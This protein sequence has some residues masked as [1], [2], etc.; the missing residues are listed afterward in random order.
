ME[1]SWGDSRRINMA[2]N[3]LKKNFG[4]RIQKVTIDAGFTC[5]NRDGTLGKG[6]CAYCN[7]DAFNPSYCTTNKPVSQQ[8]EEGIEFHEKRYKGAGKYFAYF[9]AYSNTYSSL[10]N[11]KLLYDQALAHPDVIGL[12][13]GTRPDC[14]DEQKLEY[15]ARLSEKYYVVVEYGIESVYNETLDYINRG[16]DYGK[17][18]E[19][20]ELTASYGVKSGAHFIFGLPGE[21]RDAMLTSAEIISDLPLHTIKFHQLQIIKDTRF[22]NEY[23]TDPEKFQLFTLNEYIAFISDFLAKLNPGF[24]VERLAGETQPR[25]NMGE[26]WGLRYD[27]VLN[28]I[29]KHL[30]KEDLWQ[31]KYYVP[32]QQN[33]LK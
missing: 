10:E 11:M 3:Y 21:S 9:Q 15:F 27:Q 1:F 13:V 12:I 29:E 25:N 18:V 14:I 23:K 32:V 5:P 8:V 6:G 22:A 7:N 24:I 28:R 30:V 19:A 33:V 17:S 2:S 20:L 31:G 16:H 26:S 4:M